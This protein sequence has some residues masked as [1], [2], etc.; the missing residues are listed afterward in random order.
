MALR[1]LARLFIL[2][3]SHFFFFFLH[4]GFSE[5]EMKTSYGPVCAPYEEG[6]SDRE[7]F[8]VRQSHLR[9]SGLQ[10]TLFSLAGP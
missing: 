4:R 9:S 7:E 2:L 6:R 1:V 8:R 10:F 5:I 3:A